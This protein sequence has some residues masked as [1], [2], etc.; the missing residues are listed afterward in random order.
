MSKGLRIRMLL[1][2][3]VGAV[4]ITPVYS[5]WPWPGL[6]AAMLYGGVLGVCMNIW[7]RAERASTT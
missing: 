5:F 2:L 7:M 4:A 3:L 1:L 6:V